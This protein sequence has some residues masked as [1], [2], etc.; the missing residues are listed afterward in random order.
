MNEKTNKFIFLFLALLPFVILAL[1]MVVLLVESLFYGTMDLKSLHFHTIIIHWISTIIVW[2]FGLFILNILS[3][4]A[5]YNIFE[6]KNKPALINWIIIGIIIIFSAIGSYIAW[7]M[8]FKPY[9]EFSR[10]LSRYGKIGIIAFIFQY[11]YY[12]VESM[13]FLAI[14]VFAQE[15]GERTFLKKLVPWGGIM[16][17]LTWGLGHII[18]QDLFTGIYSL[19]ISIL[20]GVVYI[21]TKKNIKYAYII[22]AIMFII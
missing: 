15:F 14:V 1:E 3:K 19:I 12:I 16:C 18:T 11:L 8:R 4:K 22:I 13:L 6:Y 7:E 17:G 2:C 5:G 9:V 10:F 20:F 21:Q